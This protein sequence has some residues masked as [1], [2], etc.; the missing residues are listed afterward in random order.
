VEHL[1]FKFSL[2]RTRRRADIDVDYR[3]SSEAKFLF[4][5]HLKSSNSDVRAGNNYF[6]HT[7]RWNA[8]PNWWQSILVSLF[9]GN[10]D[11]A[12]GSAQEDPEGPTLP[13]VRSDWEKEAEGEVHDAVQGYL[14]EW[15]VLG[16]PGGLPR[17]MSVKAY[18][19]VA[20][21]RDGSRP[22]SRLA[23]YRIMQQ[24]RCVSS[25][26]GRIGDLTAAIEPADY[27]LP[28][29]TPVNHPYA[30]PFSLQLVPD[31]VAWA[32]DCRLRY[33]LK[34]AENVPQPSNKTSGIYASAWRL[35]KDPP[36]EFRLQYWARQGAEW[37]IVSFDIKHQST[38][39]PFDIVAR[40]A[41]AFG[42]DGPTAVVSASSGAGKRRY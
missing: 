7:R 13:L 34:M 27:P 23:L 37:K 4:N 22:D 40:T 38:P 12:D 32:L 35:K 18:P 16:H 31:D 24:M 21:F 29:A 2:A 15:L 39:P 41:A 30:N 8:L 33:R 10:M 36:N 25:R 28:G 3:S 26:I 1:P 9:G 19:C 11:S 6:T 20:E 14:K 5:G 42:G 17:A